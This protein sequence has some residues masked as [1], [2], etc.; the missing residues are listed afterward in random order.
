[1]AA[2]NLSTALLPP[3][4]RAPLVLQ[5]RCASPLLFV[6][7]SYV[8]GGVG[9]AAKMH[10]ATPALQSH[11]HFARWQQAQGLVTDGAAWSRAELARRRGGSH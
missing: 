8:G 1:M 4:R 10:G 6:R 5:L 3:T 7:S 9:W 2:C 11:P